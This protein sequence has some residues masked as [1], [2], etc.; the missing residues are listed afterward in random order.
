MMFTHQ[1][2][3][4]IWHYEHYRENF[5]EKW[6]ENLC[7]QWGLNSQPSAPHH[8]RATLLSCIVPAFSAPWF[9]CSVVGLL[10]AVTIFMAGLW[11]RPVQGGIHPNNTS[12]TAMLTAR[13]YHA[14]VTHDNLCMKS[15]LKRQIKAAD[16]VTFRIIL[17]SPIGWSN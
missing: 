10:E 9:N 15:W 1:D 16:T 11:T 17:W 12:P 4:G 8:A 7:R 3:I 2:V 13:L 6:P 5:K 14:L